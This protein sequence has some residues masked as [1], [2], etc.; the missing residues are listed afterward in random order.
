MDKAGFHN[1]LPSAVVARGDNPPH[2]AEAA[3]RIRGSNKGDLAVASRHC[4]SSQLRLAEEARYIVLDSRLLHN[5]RLGHTT[6]GRRILG[7]LHETGMEI[8]VGGTR[9]PGS[10][11]A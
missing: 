6:A 5:H 3:L 11:V 4:S 7:L 10:L 8:E 9:I 1:R 2:E